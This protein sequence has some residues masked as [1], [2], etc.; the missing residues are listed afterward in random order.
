MGELIADRSNI[1]SIFQL[2]GTLENDITKSIARALC[3]CSVFM[4][5]II[6]SI[7]AEFGYMTCTNLFLGYKKYEG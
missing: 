1:M 6:N 3:N 2:I 5:Q 7:E 4:K